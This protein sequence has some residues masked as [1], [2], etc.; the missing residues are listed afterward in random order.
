MY[1]MMHQHNSGKK[2][3]LNIIKLL[4]HCLQLSFGKTWQYNLKHV[5]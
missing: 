3:Q 4:W 5:S 1:L 2:K